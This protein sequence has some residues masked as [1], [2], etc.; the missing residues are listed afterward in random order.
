MAIL[1][2]P[3]LSAGR[4][5]RS[6]V[7]ELCP[8]P[9]EARSSKAPLEAQHQ[10]NGR[11]NGR[12]GLLPTVLR[13]RCRCKEGEGSREHCAPPA[14]PQPK[15]PERATQGTRLVPCWQW[16]V[17]L[18]GRTSRQGTRRIGIQWRSWWVQAQA[19]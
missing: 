13:G 15:Q 5:R 4:G 16:K 10:G 14:R 18:E 19:Q 17:C 8:K 3:L 12:G 7:S 2:R 1:N 6:R 11:G 9:S